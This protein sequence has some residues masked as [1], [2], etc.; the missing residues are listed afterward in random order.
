MAAY[1]LP[2]VT[3]LP[4]PENAVACG[5]LRVDDPEVAAAVAAAI[6]DPVVPRMRGVL[7]LRLL[8]HRILCR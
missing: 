5:A 8:G 7:L 2:A 1:P 6:Q 3:T 4:L